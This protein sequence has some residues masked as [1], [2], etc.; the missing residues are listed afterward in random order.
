MPLILKEASDKSKTAAIVF[1]M[2]SILLLVITVMIFRLLLLETCHR[3]VCI[4]GIDISGKT[5]SEAVLII[6]QHMK[7][8]YADIKLPLR[9]GDS[10]WTLHPS[11]VAMA[12]SVERAVDS[13]F[14]AGRTGS[15]YK[16]LSE[17]YRAYRE[18]IYITCGVEFARS[19]LFFFL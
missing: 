12:F 6:E 13:A 11:D 2:T 9:Y 1:V 5:H 14:A 16:R 3:G 7:N 19:K 8:T 18:G 10:M 17:I 4:E 15:V